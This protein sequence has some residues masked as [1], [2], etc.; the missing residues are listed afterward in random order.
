MED[1]FVLIILFFCLPASNQARYVP[2][3]NESERSDSSGSEGVAVDDEDVVA[4]ASVEGDGRDDVHTG[5]A[6]LEG[7]D[8]DVRLC[9]MK[10]TA[11][12]SYEP[13]D[14]DVKKGEFIYIFCRESWRRKKKLRERKNKQLKKSL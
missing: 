8:S 4:H 12:T 14:Y 11:K 6:E 5:V 13:H 9:I 2:L 3:E 10:E 1:S 7:D